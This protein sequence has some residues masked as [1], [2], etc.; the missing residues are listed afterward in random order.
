MSQVKAYAHVDSSFSRIY[1][2]TTN[3]CFQQLHASQTDDRVL[4]E[5]RDR[6]NRLKHFRSLPPSR[7][8]FQGLLKSISP[9]IMNHTPSERENQIAS[10]AMSTLTDEEIFG[11]PES[12]DDDTTGKTETMKKALPTPASTQQSL[13]KRPLEVDNANPRVSKRRKSG[14][15]Q[16][17]TTA[18]PEKP[19]SSQ[20]F[21]DFLSQS[22]QRKFGSKYGSKKCYIPPPSPP[23]PRKKE[24]SKHIDMPSSPAKTPP[25]KKS[26]HNSTI[27]MP[28]GSPNGA[29]APVVLQLPEG[30]DD[31]N[32]ND[33]DTE[34]GLDPNLDIGQN[35]SKP[36]ISRRRSG[37]TT[38]LSSVDSISSL[39]LD[40][41]TKRR[42]MEEQDAL[43][44]SIDLPPDCVR[45][46]MCHR[47]VSREHLDVPED[48][49]DLSK[50]TVLN[51]QKFCYDHRLRDAQS[52][53]TAAGYPVLDFES[54]LSSERVK[55][56]VRGLKDVIK[57]DRKSYYLSHLDN[58]VSAAKGHQ[59]KIK[60]YFDVTVLALIHLGYYGPKG[61]RMLS[62]AI[63][64]DVE[65]G[66]L[67]SRGMRTDKAFKVAGLTRIVNCVL[68]PELLTRL[69]QEDML[70]SKGEEG[71]EEARK[72][73]EDSTD[74]G[75]MLCADD[76]HVEEQLDEEDDDN[77]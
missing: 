58:A 36:D 9:K 44:V 35:T 32:D 37:S 33:I 22:S 20:D 45:C 34:P 14:K 62:H 55:K 19:P 17:A 3:N 72:I 25:P 7:K 12:S 2:T 41:S 4:A 43:Q 47:P 11:L 60:Q 39:Q 27:E 5:I 40:K 24:N 56:H 48:L 71:E 52:A 29:A 70:L 69:V 75:L 13:P 77:V 51:Q 1:L 57:R 65:I 30:F 23:S 18:M 28:E 53:W 26:K 16:E 54:F 68:L 31:E 21:P 10:A 66:R 61:A 73:L 50:Y 74:A 46:P 6:N 15:V 42:L 59:G 76:D 8:H 38:S 64:D 49:R 67:L 63:A